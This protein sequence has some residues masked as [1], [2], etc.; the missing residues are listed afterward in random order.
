MTCTTH[1]CFVQGVAL[2]ARAMLT[3][4][5]EIALI[6]AIKLTYG[7]GMNGV[8]G[9]TYYNRWKTGK[10][11]TEEIHPFVEVSAFTQESIVQLAGTT[12][13]ELGH[14]LAGWSAGHDKAWKE[15]C[16]RLGLRAIKA[17]GTRYHWANF[18]PKLR[19]AILALPMP[20]D[21]QPVNNLPGF[22][23]GNRK[24]GPKA[25]TAAIGTRGGTSR[26]P[27]SGSRLRKFV[28]G[29]GAIIRASR[30]DA[31]CSCSHCG[32]AYLPA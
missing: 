31:Q 13:H 17:A 25:C 27:G 23:I 3:D 29:H 11:G 20:D 14:V 1:E 4:P 10:G 2:A 6:D 5:A 24:S 21:G 8:R 19:F 22:K 7:A 32:T 28:C 9:V 26:G 18:D 16:K 15:A 30:D 12:I